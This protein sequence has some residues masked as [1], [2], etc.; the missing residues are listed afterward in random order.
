MTDLLQDDPAA[1]ILA[2]D[3]AWVYAQA[4]PT[5]VWSPIGHPPVVAVSPQR[6]CLVFYG[7]LDLR[8]GE[9]YAIMTDK[10]NQ[11]TSATFLEAVVARFPGRRVLVIGDNASWHKGLPINRLLADHPCL[12]LFY[13]PVACPDLNP[14]EHVW[15]VVRRTVPPQVNSPRFAD[16]AQ[17]FLVT[18]RRTRLRPPLFEHYAP[19]ILSVL[20]G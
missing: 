7:A 3:E 15:A 2:W 9:E 18:L 11:R 5:V 6:D 20:T 12:S 19:P 8:T 10:M 13:L 16:L 4:A 1:V 14:Q 17:A